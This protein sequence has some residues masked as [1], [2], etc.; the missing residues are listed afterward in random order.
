MAN[1]SL[2]NHNNPY[3]SENRVEIAV[4]WWKRPM[5]WLKSPLDRL[6][7]GCLVADLLTLLVVWFVLLP[8]ARESN[9][10]LI[11]INGQVDVQIQALLK[12]Q[13]SIGT[14]QKAIEHL[15][16]QGRNE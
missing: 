1:A 9:E 15:M 2:A 7:F 13:Q 3:L 16:K 11:K 12:N 14:N 10:T 5:G 4:R 6:A 8:V